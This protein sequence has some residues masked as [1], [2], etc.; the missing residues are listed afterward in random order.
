MLLCAIP[1]CR[2]RAQVIGA[3]T[4]LFCASVLVS[5]ACAQSSPQDVVEKGAAPVVTWVSQNKSADELAS[6]MTDLYLTLFNSDP[7]RL[8]VQSPTQVTG[9]TTIG[10]EFRKRGLFFRDQLPLTL[11][12]L[13]CDLNEH[14]C[15]RVKERASAA[16]LIS[17]TRHLRGLKPSVPSWQLQEGSSLLLP[18]IKFR[19]FVRWI[20]YV[21][22]GS[23]S[24]D[25]IVTNE[26]QGCEA[27][28]SKCRLSIMNFNR[29]GE[30]VFEQGFGGEGGIVL[31]LPVISA[32]AEVDIGSAGESPS[33]GPPITLPRPNGSVTLE[34]Q[35]P[36]RGSS[37][38]NVPERFK[39]S[40]PAISLPR[41]GNLNDVVR[42]LDRNLLAPPKIRIDST[43]LVL[44]EDLSVHQTRFG[45]GL[46]LPY[47]SPASYPSK[48]RWPVGVLVMDQWVDDTHC[49]LVRTPG[50][51]PPSRAVDIRNLATRSIQS[52]A[53]CNEESDASIAGDHGTHVTGIIAARTADG[54]LWGVNPFAQVYT[55]E[56]NPSESTTSG[57]HIATE[58]ADA[59]TA[60]QIVA[61]NLSW[62]WVRTELRAP[63]LIEQAIEGA[64]YVLFVAAAGN[65][66]QRMDHICDYR[67]ACYELPNVISVAALT[68][69][70][71]DPK[72]WL[73]PD[74][75]QGTNYG[76]F[77][78]VAAPGQDIFSTIS[79][80][81]FGLM[82]G[83]S[84]AAPQVTAL[85]SL[86]FAKH[87]GRLD[88]KQ[89][90]D[91][92]IYC[93]EI[94][95]S[96]I[97]KLRGGRVNADCTLDDEFARVITSSPGQPVHGKAQDG[98]LKF[99][100]D[101]ADIRFETRQVKGIQ[102]TDGG[103]FTVFYQ[104]GSGPAARMQKETDLRL[105]DLS[106][107]I[108]FGNPDSS[109]PD[110][111]IGIKDILHYA[112]PMQ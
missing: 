82:S 45:K 54:A 99:S 80:G 12:S 75:S 63:D 27:L 104:I 41:L 77:I 43:N 35:E 65:D 103:R 88:P 74:R 55:R 13:A 16:E 5:S 105:S 90:K 29:K 34:K 108:T 15:Q 106:Q 93:S 11:E 71:T 83:T 87:Q 42:Q 86:L 102:T 19:T 28:D 68:S 95:P 59:L 58:L 40:P 112:A 17:P 52:R 67:A 2:P 10:L 81:R 6:Q 32:R 20:P 69:D 38:P 9:P 60:N 84:Q 72:L 1:L 50:M 57:E 73:D 23:R 64:P 51:A 110:F 79:G 4:F 85:A 94:T 98:Q 44:S 97:N 70:A 89:V 48:L 76:K 109:K 3:F 37:E 61:V 53:N 24:I 36:L 26:L 78:D 46:V 101:G 31:S 25:D 91:R 96:L 111:Q 21:K 49:A 22:Y 8:T 56:I 107:A 62:G 92:L 100:R 33:T 7:P 14:L 30:E 66:G 39:L 18:G 47:N